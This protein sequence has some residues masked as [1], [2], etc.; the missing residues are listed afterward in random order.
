MLHFLFSVAIVLIP[1]NLSAY[2]KI[3][4]KLQIINPALARISAVAVMDGKILAADSKAN[5]VFI[6]D[7]AGKL[8][9]KS[10]APLKEPGGLSVG[11]GR[12]Y[13]ADTGNSRIVVLSADGMLQWAFSG[14]GTL[15]GQLDSPLDA[16]FGPD[17][18]VYVADTGNSRVQVFNSDGIFLY[19]FPVLKADK[20]TRLN[21]AKVVVDNAGSI[22][23]SDP[24]NSV[25]VKYDR[26]GNPLKSYN[27]A[28]NGLAVDAYGVLY[29]IS[30]KEGK[31]REVSEAGEILGTFGTKGKGK[32]EFM[33]LSGIAL[34]PEGVIYLADEGNNKLTVIRM[35]GEKPAAKLAQA[36]PL[37]RFTLKGPVKKYQ[38][39]SDMFAIK[40]D[41]SVAAYL[42]ETR[43]TLLL[44]DAGKKALLPY[45]AKQGQV[46]GPRGMKTDAAGRLYVS[47]T[48]NNR[49]QVFGAD[50]SFLNMF[51]NSGSKEGNFSGPA[52]I[53]VS[54]KG[55]IYVAD[56]G[57]RRMQAFNSDGIFLFAVGPQVGGL[58]LKNPV[59]V[60]VCTNKNLYILDAALKKVIVTDANGKFLRVW[61]DSGK[62]QEPVAM[63]YDGK[64]Y[65]YILDR[66]SFSI[67]IFDDQG[68]YISG[69]FAKGS[70]ERE[71]MDPRYLDFADNKLYVSD[72]SSG[73]ILAFALSYLPEEPFSLSYSTRT[74]GIV[75]S[76]QEKKTPWLKN[77]SV[78]RADSPGGEYK[79]LGV[80]DTAEYA[81]AG[82]AFD[83]T[84]YYSA[85]GVSVTG[86]T[87]SLSVPL[88][89]CLK[90]PVAAIAAAPELPANDGPAARN[91]A[92][93]EIVPGGPVGLSY[94]F[95]A[96]YKYYMKNPI[97][98]IAVQNNT[99][100]AF[101][102][103]KVSFFLKDFMDFPSDTIV[104]EIAPKSKAE[105]DL[106]ATLNNRIL[107]INEDTPIQC[108]LTMTYYQDG[109]EKTFTLNQP[110]K[111]LSKNA[112][113]W[114][115]ADRL[116]N[117]ITPKD[118][119]VFS[120]SRFVLNEKNKY[121]DEYSLLNGD[122]LSAM[123]IWEGLGEVGLSYLA[124]PVS[125][126]SVKKSSK[127]FTIDTVQFPRN[128]LKLRSG[129]CDDLTALFASVLEASGLHTVI[130]DYP[131]HIALMFDTGA[132]DARDAGIPEE[133]LI[134]Y[135]NTYWI[136]V[137]TTMVGKD[138]YDSVKHEADLY[139]SMS[140]D[141]KIVD[142]RTAWAEFEP[143]TLPES[144][145]ESNPDRA[146][147]NAR[148]KEAAAGMYKARYDYLKKYYGQILLENPE[149]E[150]ANINLGILSAQAG[151]PAEADKYFENILAKDPVNAA[152]LNNQGNLSFKAGKY[153][154]A[155]DSYL[156]A[157]KA[158]PY[159]AN[160][161]LNAARVSAKLGK[162]ED[163][164][165]FTD[166]AARLDPETKN[167]GDK[168]LK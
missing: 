35:E 137:E 167:V 59:S 81:D 67:K 2:E 84:Y 63:A 146:K 82:L 50:G 110:V 98:R 139:R 133:Y 168:L 107:N 127:E 52:G 144:E 89:V 71:L 72:F 128:T 57:N 18:R 75:L 37:D 150:D 24:E 152:A 9:K 41:L 158:D 33:K 51:G 122:V 135:N 47:D 140:A 8:L 143:V 49:V 6:F 38:Y 92:P 40:P 115:K 149:D 145:A 11:N 157:A 103:V 66:G 154:E 54:D 155:R 166:R 69:F 91:V 10:S 116:A 22:Y 27:F 65:F 42:P 160:V 32:V 64:T 161:W 36:R 163:V 159:D 86:D 132:T 34:D 20:V 96:N 31:V 14:E 104:K 79:Q 113:I 46:K 134:K 148:V 68:K 56:P 111:V 126:Y 80:T 141:V 114:D 3:E 124:D 55:N 105:V 30:A 85:A 102:N 156:K 88:A 16:A 12:I 130:L 19:G 87:G 73:K 125:P 123:M 78:F 106:M 53:T 39:K 94:V 45:G 5:A 44:S 29:A 162:K 48:G 1:A 101:S 117:F 62:T 109:A 151:E 121:Q 17:G 43:E 21:P 136:G 15:P 26:A 142:V 23:V 13:V 147:F 99:D 95:S 93:M 76:W 74:E 60:R 25:I 131:T 58:T 77:S 97:G 112:V 120:F 108:Q 165:A 164:K 28:N 4:F 153:Q 129:D 61:D 119:P 100:I 70:G 83:T 7:S 90:S 118:T 138:F